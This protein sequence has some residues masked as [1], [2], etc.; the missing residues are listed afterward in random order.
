MLKHYK[1]KVENLFDKKIKVIRS[2]K[3]GKYKASFGKF[4]SQNEIIYQ[5][6]A[7]YSS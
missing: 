1:N 2:D 7:P 6:T 4:C 5:T 3:C